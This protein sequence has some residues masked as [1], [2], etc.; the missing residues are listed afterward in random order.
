MSYRTYIRILLKN[1][2][3]KGIGSVNLE[4]A[5]THKE[6]KRKIRRYVNTEQ[7]IYKTDFGSKGIKTHRT[8][9]KSLSHLI[10]IKKQE[11]ANL[12]RNLEIQHGEITPAIYDQSQQ[13]SAY[14]RKDIFELY[15]KFISFKKKKVDQRTIKKYNSLRIALEEFVSQSKF[16]K[17]FTSDITIEFLSDFEGYLK[18]ERSLSD[19]TINKYQSCFQ[20]FMDYLTKTIKINKNLA[21]N[22]FVKTSRDTDSE[23]KIVLLKEHVEKIVNWIPENE[24]YEKVR[25]LFVFQILTGIRFSD[26]ERVKK[27]FIRGESLSFVMFKTKRRATIPL[28]PKAS[29]ILQKY[30]YSLGEICKSVKNYNLD[31]KEVCKRAGLTEEVSGLEMKLNEKI[32]NDTPIYKLVSSHVAR[33]TFVTNCLVSGITP[34]IVM[35]YTGHKKIETLKIYMKLAGSISQDA[36]KKYEEYFSFE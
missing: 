9:L 7:Y 27:S 3:E 2:N 11:L 17:I 1:T 15:D 30:D 28:H 22:D 10:N 31:I 29:E 5:F 36:F 32:S 16:K 24:R 18:D 20:T 25:D 23:S 35:G 21:Y 12:I 6:T 8:D 26:L 33:T 4:I 19:N 13:I 34:F 14:S